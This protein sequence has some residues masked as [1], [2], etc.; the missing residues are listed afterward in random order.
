MVVEKY[1][2]H[3]ELPAEVMERSRKVMLDVMWEKKRIDYA[4][5]EGM[6]EQ[7]R[8]TASRVNTERQAY[9]RGS[10]SFS[11]LFAA[12]LE[13]TLDVM[14]PRI[15]ETLVSVA[16]IFGVRRTSE[17]VYRPS[18]NRSYEMSDRQ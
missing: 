1:P 12:E 11:Q 2:Y 15:E 4:G 17:S 3:E 8:D 10:Q 9:P 13:G 16:G 14:F 6:P 5:L 18:S 7:P